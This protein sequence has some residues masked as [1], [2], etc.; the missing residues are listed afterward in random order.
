LAHH[1]RGGEKNHV[2]HAER[3]E[4]QEGF[5][6]IELMIVVAIIGI[7]A[8]HRHPELPALPGE[9]EAVRGQDEPGRD[10][11]GGNLLFRGEQRVRAPERCQ[12]GAD[13]TTRYRY[14]S[15]GAT[16]LGNQSI[17]IAAAA[18]NGTT[19]AVSNTTPARFTAG[20]QGNIDT[21]ATMDA[22]TIN[23]ARILDPRNADVTL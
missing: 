14:T 21:D 16:D 9:V 8:A 1:S 5:T 11:H 2:E 23:D 4:G 13:R 18:W 22:W 6:L 17:T 12:L 20:A 10:L 3:Q 15:G 7:L 19:P